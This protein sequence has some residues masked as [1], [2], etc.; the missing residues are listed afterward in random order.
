M[1]LPGI[2]SLLD[3]KAVIS[4]LSAVGGALLTKFVA[5][6][7]ER[8]KVLEYTVTHDR[9]GLSAEDAIFGSVRVTWEGH[10]LR[11]LYAST[12]VIENTT[13]S[14]HTNLK[15]KVYTG[16]TLLLN[17]RSE[18][19]GTTHIATWTDEYRQ[20]LQVAGQAPTE[21]QVYAYRH[22]REYI[23]SVFNRDQRVVLTYLTT[24]P[25]ADEGPSV[26]ADMLHPGVRV[27]FRPLAQ[28]IFGVPVPLALPLGLVV[29]L[30]MLV[31]IS[32][33]VK[34]PW[35][36]ALLSLMSGLAVQSIGAGIY[37]ALR[38]LKQVILR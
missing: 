31:A 3:N 27:A 9:L 7:R 29:C 32:V 21:A 35:L 12:V 4:G 16:K 2:G 38:F 33:Y 22:T 25:D 10:E 28:Q 1:D 26:W 18:I 13:G 17:E 37:R 34:Q 23:L 6:Y 30:A 36:A 11:N 8:I 15:L 19:A 5:R 14:D 24:V 20:S